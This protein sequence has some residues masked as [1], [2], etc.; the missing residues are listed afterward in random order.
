MA[1]GNKVYYS[2][3]PSLSCFVEMDYGLDYDELPGFLLLLSSKSRL[4][5]SLVS[6]LLPLLPALT[7]VT[8]WG[9]GV[10]GYF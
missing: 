8:H 4:N 9:W 1:Q 10:G 5:G 3:T 6:F 7:L 2:L